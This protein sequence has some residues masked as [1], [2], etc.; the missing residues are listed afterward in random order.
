MFKTVTA[1]SLKPKFTV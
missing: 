1:K